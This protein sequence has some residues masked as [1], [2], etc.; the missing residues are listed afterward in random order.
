[1]CGS[2]RTPYAAGMPNLAGA[3]GN[4]AW[5]DGGA[6]VPD[7]ATEEGNDPWGDAAAL[8]KEAHWADAS[9]E[10]EGVLLG[11]AA[12][13]AA[14]GVPLHSRYGERIAAPSSPFPLFS[15]HPVGW[16][17]PWCRLGRCTPQTVLSPVQ[18]PT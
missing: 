17:S 12:Y 13:G 18:F 6:R 14:W 11:G 8:G 7:L 15:G 9:A 16:G 4:D 3:E 5:G 10:D 2:C 1:M